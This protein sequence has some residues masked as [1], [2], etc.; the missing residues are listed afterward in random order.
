M[1]TPS[2]RALQGAAA[3]ALALPAG[4]VTAAPEA[5]A[6]L[7]GLAAEID[8]LCAIGREIQAKRVDPFTEK[9]LRLMRDGPGPSQ[10]PISFGPQ[11]PI[12]QDRSPP[13]LPTPFGPISFGPKE[14]AALAFAYSDESG[15]EAAIEERNELDVE[16]DRLWE[17]MRTIP[18]AT[19]AGRAA[20]VR[21]LLAHVCPSKWRGPSNDLDWEI[22]QARALL[23]EFASMSEEELAL[24]GK[25]V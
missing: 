9:F 14:R 25:V 21:A 8:R 6:E 22:Q 18:A 16:I 12:G 19:P 7:V 5:D 13:G 11:E 3:V 20:K 23:G 4:A 17:R 2:K 15:R 24:A 10:E 1:T